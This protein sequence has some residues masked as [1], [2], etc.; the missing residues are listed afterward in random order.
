MK[1]CVWGVGSLQKMC[2]PPLN[3]RT[4]PQHLA[5]RTRGCIARHMGAD[6]DVADFVGNDSGR[7][8]QHPAKVLAGKKPS[9]K[10]SPRSYSNIPHIQSCQHRRHER[11][12]GL[13]LC[14]LF[15]GSLC[16]PL[17]VASPSVLVGVVWSQAHRLTAILW[18]E[19]QASLLSCPLG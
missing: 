11:F 5:S 7:R 13:G 1:E 6:A 19:R 12:L 9:R 2:G 8:C 16:C 10:C 17:S 18:I 15:L 4:G 14:L 3:T